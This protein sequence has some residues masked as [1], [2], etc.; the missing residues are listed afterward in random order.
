MA[1]FLSVS[2]TRLF[3]LDSAKVSLPIWLW[4]SLGL[5]GEEASC[6]GPF[7][8]GLCLTQEYLGMRRKLFWSDFLSHRRTSLPFGSKL[9]PCPGTPW[10]SCPCLPCHP[11]L[12]RSLC[13][14]QPNGSGLTSHCLSIPGLQ[15]I[16]VYQQ[17]TPSSVFTLGGIYCSLQWRETDLWLKS[18]RFGASEFLGYS[19]IGTAFPDCFWL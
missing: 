18:G 11:L 7:W 10:H 16:P 15:P 1:I 2:L 8:Q 13:D 12:P 6:S 4:Q 19:A 14:A 17:W 3:C 9:L 5:N